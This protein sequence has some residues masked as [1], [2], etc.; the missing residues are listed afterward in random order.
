[1]KTAESTVVPSNPAIPTGPMCPKPTASAPSQSNAESDLTTVPYTLRTH[2]ANVEKPSEPAASEPLPSENTQN[3]KMNAVHVS[4][5]GFPSLTPLRERFGASGTTSAPA[6]QSSVPTQKPAHPITLKDLIPAVIKDRKFR[7]H[8]FAASLTQEQRVLLF[9]WLGEDSL[10]EVKA[11]VAAPAPEGFGL[12]VHRTTLQRLRNSVENVNLSEAVIDAMDS[13][14]DVLDSEVIADAAPLRET[15]SFLLYARAVRTAQ[16]ADA[17]DI[18]RIIT[19]I[20]KLE[21]LKPTTAARPQPLA[22][23]KIDLTVANAQREA[24]IAQS[25]AATPDSAIESKPTLELQ[26]APRP[27]DKEPTT[28]QPAAPT[29]DPDSD[30]ASSALS[31]AP[32]AGL[33]ANSQLSAQLHQG[34]NRLCG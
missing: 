2:Y 16:D 33:C 25:V 20:T 24:A 1:M 32:S 21:K 29:S 23:L 15:L 12:K 13:A 14:C 17:V 30:A 7:A 4:T 26:S 8:S 28:T 22:R 34:S 27:A 6:S 18:T 10:S 9:E 3:Q 5:S 31:S 19:A 11:K